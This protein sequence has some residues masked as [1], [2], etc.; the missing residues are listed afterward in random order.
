MPTKIGSIPLSMSRSLWSMASVIYCKDSNILGI[1]VC[2]HLRHIV[3]KMQKQKKIFRL[4]NQAKLRYFHR[5]PSSNLV[6]KYPVSIDALWHD[7]SY[8]NTKCWFNAPV[9]R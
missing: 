4:P 9:W 5:A 7:K 2:K 6:L 1:Y 3:A 8:G